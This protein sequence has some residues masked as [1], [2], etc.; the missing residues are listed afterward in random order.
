MTAAGILRIPC[1]NSAP[2]R[3]RYEGRESIIADSGN[4]AWRDRSGAGTYRRSTLG[5]RR[6]TFAVADLDSA[7]G[8]L[9]CHVGCWRCH[10]CGVD[11]L[12]SEMTSFRTL[13][14]ADVSGARVLLRVD[15]NV[16]MEHGRVTDATRL[17][18]IVPTILEIADKGGKVILLS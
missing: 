6:S 17:D 9:D 7:S 2:S 1:L 5:Y 11:S 13:D 16:P 18:R 4:E 12:R 10:R 3:R 14:Q 15:L 8:R